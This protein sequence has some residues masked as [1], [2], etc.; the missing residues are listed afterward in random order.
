MTPSENQKKY[1]EAMDK[2]LET[3]DKKYWDIIWSCIHFCNSNI[4]KKMLKGIYSYTSDDIEEFTTD[5][6]IYCMSR[7]SE[8]NAVPDTLSAWCYLRCMAILRKPVKVWYDQHM[9]NLSDYSEEDEEM[10]M[11]NFAENGGNNLTDTEE[12][13]KIID[14]VHKGRISMR[15]VLQMMSE[16]KDAGYNED[17]I[18]SFVEDKY[19]GDY[20]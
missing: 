7:I 11:R 19:G 9:R 2:W 15:Q 10:I 12:F 13:K 1:K 20:E 5:A 8:H 4:I 16:L 14:I 17:E 3:R 6:T 18:M